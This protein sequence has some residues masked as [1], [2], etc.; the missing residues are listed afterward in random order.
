M[1]LINSIQNR[2]CF[3]QRVKEK[4]CGA[5]DF[6]GKDFVYCFMSRIIL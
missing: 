4:L 6:G 3:P 1:E 5:D 2:Y